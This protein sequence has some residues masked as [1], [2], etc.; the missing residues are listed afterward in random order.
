MTSMVIFTKRLQVACCRMLHQ[1]S[2]PNVENDHYDTMA[3]AYLQ[4]AGLCL[5]RAKPI[6]MKKATSTLDSDVLKT[7]CKSMAEGSRLKSWISGFT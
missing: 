5:A 1:T 3:M 4:L 2:S 6:S 7:G